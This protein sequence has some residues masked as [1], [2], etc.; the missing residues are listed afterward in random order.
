MSR[1]M[2]W[3]KLGIFELARHPHK[4]K[5]VKGA[6]GIYKYKEKYNPLKSKKK[7]I[8]FFVTDILKTG[9]II[10]HTKRGQLRA[11]QSPNKKFLSI[12]KRKKKFS[13]YR[14]N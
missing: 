7:A 10:G 2:N 11:I 14:N 4:F 1:K 5:K 6:K 3:S 13:I 12:A 9:L 8:P